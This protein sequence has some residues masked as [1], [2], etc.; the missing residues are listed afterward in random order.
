MLLLLIIGSTNCVCTINLLPLLSAIFSLSVTLPDSYSKP[1][2]TQHPFSFHVQAQIFKLCG[3]NL[4]GIFPVSDL[5]AYSSR[6][7]QRCTGGFTQTL[8]PVCFQLVFTNWDFAR[9]IRYGIGHTGI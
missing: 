3:Q 1:P 9:L 7:V 4:P 2:L 5:F 6:Y 8:T